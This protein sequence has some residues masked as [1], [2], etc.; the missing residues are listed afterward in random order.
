MSERE[1]KVLKTKG[2]V[3]VVYVGWVSGGENNQLQSVYLKNVKL[4][5]KGDIES[6]NPLSEFEAQQKSIE[7]FVVSI[8]GSKEDILKQVEALPISDY[9]EIIEALNEISKSK[10]KVTL[11]P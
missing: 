8:N 10:K 1:T 7:L 3:E 11:T 9:N 6:F 5:A 2:G 4:D